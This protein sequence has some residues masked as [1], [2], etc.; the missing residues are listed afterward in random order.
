MVCCNRDGKIKSG[1]IPDVYL[2]PK[3]DDAMLDD[4]VAYLKGT[5]LP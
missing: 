4:I 1:W 3:E 2:V 5:Q